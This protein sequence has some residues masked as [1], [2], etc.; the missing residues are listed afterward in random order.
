MSLARLVYPAM[1][2]NR[3]DASSYL[4]AITERAGSLSRS[5]IVSGRMLAS[6]RSLR[7]YSASMARS[8]RSVSRSVYQRVARIITTDDTTELMKRQ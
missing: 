8:A 2:A 6:S 7:S 1:S 5:A 4:S 3:I